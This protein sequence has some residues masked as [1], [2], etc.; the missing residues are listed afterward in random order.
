MIDDITAPTFTAPAN[1]TIS[2]D[3]SCGY[4]ASIGITGD[5]TDEADNCSTSLNATF[6]DNI[7]P[8]GCDGGKTITRTWSLT[9]NC[10]NTTMHNQT[11]TV[12]DN[13]PPTFTVPADV[14]IYT[15]ANCEYNSNMLFGDVTDEDDNCSEFID[16]FPTDGAPVMGS[17][18]GSWTIARSWSL[19]DDC[20]N[21]IIHIQ[22]ITVNDNTPP[23]FTAPADITIFKDAVCDYDS[24]V[25]AT[26]DVINEVDNCSVGIEASFNDTTVPGLCEGSLVITR[27]W[28][29]TDL[30]GNAALNQIQTIT[31]SDNTPPSFTEPEDI[32]I[33]KNNMCAYD[34]SVGVTGNVTNESDNCD[35]SLDATF[36][37][38]VTAG[39][40]EGQEIITRTWT[41]TDDCGN[42]TQHVQIIT[43]RDNIGPV[44]TAPSAIE[45]EC[46]TNLPAP[47]TSITQFL[48]LAGA[49]ATDNCS[50]QSNLQV[51]SV[52]GSL[53]GTNCN[54]SLTRTYIVTDGCGNS[55]TVNQT[56]NVSDN[57]IPSVTAGGIA[58]CYE[59]VAMAEAAAVDATIATDNCSDTLT[60]DVNTTTG[61]CDSTITVTV[62]DE[63]GNS[64]HVV[65]ETRINCQAVRLKVI[66]EGPYD[67]VGDSM[68]T[69]LNNAHLLP[70]QNT[71]LPFI[72]DTPSGQPYNTPP[73]NYNGNTGMLYGDAPYGTVPYPS[74]VVDWVLVSVREEG[75]LPANTIWT[76]AGWVHK[77][78]TVTFP[79]N[80]IAPTINIQNDYYIV[81]QHRNHLGIMSPSFVD[82][83][84]SG[85]YLNWDFTLE[86]SYKPAF[87]TG[88]KLMDGI[89]AM[90][91][92][93]GEQVNTIKVISSPDLT[94]W[95]QQQGSSGYKK[96]DYNMNISA[97][98]ADETNWKTNQNKT[99]GVIFY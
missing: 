82:I 5:V 90:L 60:Y 30:C 39:V 55:S 13:I 72:G 83:E 85:A 36:G 93:N 96:G 75:I 10:G 81:V 47:A 80:C 73:Y 29:L 64:D 15:D 7:V 98:S 68:K 87:R 9:D 12:I 88:Q 59:T 31:V 61:I 32:T 84:C 35:T 57:T 54:G 44:I 25:D 86:D 34:A 28:S 95:G 94:V 63:C 70:G 2:T 71:T 49:T 91:A 16:A 67:S 79:D 48:A 42:N 21:E 33:F 62:T 14:T 46:S 97:N 3:A 74:D 53:V 69:T 6:N 27:T 23:T 41:L 56:F 8:G 37:D 92:G 50:V 78:G 65:Y 76:C 58:D 52:T 51:G 11:I 40:C 66:M 17:C 1:I 43:A 4:D 19:V 77:N 26:G 89:W 99:T 20:G 45:L 38:M 24:G 22:M 18:P